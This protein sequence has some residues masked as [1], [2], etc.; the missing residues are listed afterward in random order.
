[1]I[2]SVPLEN[3]PFIDSFADDCCLGQTIGTKTACGV[4]RQGIDREGAIAIDNNALRFKPLV[5]PGWA[6]QGIAYGKYQR[7][8]GLALA[9]LLLNGHNTSQAETMEWFYKRIPRWFKGSE[10]ES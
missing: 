3:Q 5:Q 6:R 2:D 10:T 4:T 9:V 7:T 1:M 8:N